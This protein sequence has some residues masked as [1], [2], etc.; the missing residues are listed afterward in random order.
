[1]VV[2]PSH[3]PPLYLQE[4]SPVLISVTWLIRC[5]GQRAAGTPDHPGCNAVS[6]KMRLP[7]IHITKIQNKTVILALIFT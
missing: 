7:L 2:S 3:R 5:Q 4:I 6:S 1:M